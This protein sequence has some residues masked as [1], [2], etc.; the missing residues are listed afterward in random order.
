MTRLS[1]R[2]RVEPFHVMEL[3]KAAGQRAL[4]G[5]DVIS[6]CAGQPSTP[7]PAVARAAAISALHRGDVLGYTD[8]LGTAALRQAISD[9]YLRTYDFDVDPG[10]VVVTTGSSAAFT[11]LFL[12]C[13]DPGDRVVMTRP[14]YPAYRN[15]LTA[16][17]CRV[18]E[19]DC[20]PDVRF[21]LTAAALEAYA[22]RSGPPAGL[23]VASP[24]N[25]TGTVVHPD[26]LAAIVRW[27]DAHDVVLVSDEIY[28]GVTYTGP[29]SSA[30]QTSRQGVLVGS[31]S[32]FFSMT[33][34]RVGWLVVPPDL[35]RPLEL[36][37]GNLNICAPA[38]A[39]V[40]AAAA[41]S[42]A[43]R[44]ELVGHVERYA[45][46]RNLLLRRLPDLGLTSMAPPDGAFYAYLDV[47]HLTEDS[48]RWCYDVLDATGVALTPGVDFAPDRA[49]PHGEPSPLD[50]SR[51]VRLSFAGATAEIDEAVTRLAAYL[52]ATT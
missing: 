49:G 43:A 22:D 50:G 6:L 34:W 30:W 21:S 48:G 14:G 18:D 44:P 5:G 12:A 42:E 35:V 51:F 36:L 27:C 13:F 7:A 25:P 23:I 32:K 20:G 37:L 52:D 29:A 8:A 10:Q 38:I 3:I 26:E 4:K 19:L 2:G 1:A 15:T 28:H 40:A 11:A 17:G 24:A 9:H 31:V 41:L 33:G 45:V 16:L 47:S 46:N 39:Q